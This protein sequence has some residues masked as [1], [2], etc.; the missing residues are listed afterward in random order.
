M[1][2]VAFVFVAG[3]GGGRP[4]QATPRADLFAALGRRAGRRRLRRDTPTTT[5]TRHQ[6]AP[7]RPRRVHQEGHPDRGAGDPGGAPSSATRAAAGSRT[8]ARPSGRPGSRRPA[9]TSTSGSPE[10]AASCLAG[11]V[12]RRAPTPRPLLAWPC[13][14]APVLL[15]PWPIIR[16]GEGQGARRASWSATFVGGATDPPG[17]RGG[18]RAAAAGKPDQTTDRPRV[19]G[20]GH[21]HDAGPVPARRVQS[22]RLWLH[23]DPATYVKVQDLARRRHVPDQRSAGRAAHARRQGQ[24]DVRVT[25]RRRGHGA[26]RTSRF[27]CVGEPVPTETT[28]TAPTLTHRTRRPRVPT[29]RSRP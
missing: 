5:G 24:P 4:G 29:D 8:A 1:L 19:G 27:T 3:L 10:P 13:P 18:A 2:T 15:A 22:L 7:T 21:G 20:R 25:G 14:H 6:A 16:R 26:R 11:L 28:A 23:N 12:H 9:C 17:R